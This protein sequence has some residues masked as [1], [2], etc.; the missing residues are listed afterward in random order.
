M[1]L[2]SERLVPAGAGRL[3]HRLSF[4][5]LPDGA[6]VL[7]DRMPWLVLGRRL[8]EWSPMGYRAALPRPTGGVA[9]VITPR[10]LLALLGLG[11]EPAVP[12]LHPSATG[13]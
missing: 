6:F 4:D 13:G 1:Q 11:W 3:L 8:L 2:H 7:R 5:E 9:S 10:S 12:L